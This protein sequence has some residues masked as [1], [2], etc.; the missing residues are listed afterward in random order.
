MAAVFTLDRT[1]TGTLRKA[2]PETATSCVCVSWSHNLMSSNSYLVLYLFLR[3]LIPSPHQSIVS[4][5]FFSLFYHASCLNLFLSSLV[6]MLGCN[7][8]RIASIH[9]LLYF[10]S[11]LIFL[12]ST[13]SG[14]ALLSYLRLVL[15][16][17][18]PNSLC[19]SLTVSPHHLSPSLLVPL[20]ILV[21]EPFLPLWITWSI[22]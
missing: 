12:R 4:S 20:F 11:F 10:P 19:F 9:L 21:F 1:A 17:F 14:L 13:L 22:L 3:S 16:P 7:M 15:I 18:Y 8:A 6:Y 2:R 5:I